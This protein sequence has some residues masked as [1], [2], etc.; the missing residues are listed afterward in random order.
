[1]IIKIVF[2]LVSAIAL[3]SQAAPMRYDE[4]AQ[5]VYSDAKITFTGMHINAYIPDASLAKTIGDFIRIPGDEAPLQFG[6]YALIDGCRRHSCI[7]KAAVVVDM[8]TRTIAAV[9]LRNFECRHVVMDDSDIAAIALNS[10]KRATSRCNEAPILDVYVVRRSLKPEALRN[11]REQ[12]LQ[13]RQWGT[14]VGH[15]G[16]KI[17]ILVR[18]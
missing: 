14:R 6:H 15:Q 1:M 17:Q 18:Y 10:G 11:E 13:L 4:V 16:E 12:L 8:R 9:A 5:I 7:E 2:A 3:P